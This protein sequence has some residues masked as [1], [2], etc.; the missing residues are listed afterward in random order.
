MKTD[1][2][3]AALAADGHRGIAVP[4]RLAGGLVAGLAISFVVFLAAFGIRADLV[5]ALES[6][7]FDVKVALLALAVVVSSI[8]CRRA[9]EPM[10]QS[11]GAL[12]WLVPAAL[13]VAVAGELASSPASSW[14]ARLVG[15]NAK[16]CLT[17]IPMLALAPLVLALIALR[18]AAPRSPM[19][20]GAA[21]GFA[22][23]AIAA[24]LYGLHCFDDSPLFVATWYPLASVPVVLAGAVAG[25]RLLR[26]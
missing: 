17:A 21:A 16:V 20:A 9:A 23:S 13:A 19:L 1:E 15:T 24:V 5:P 11:H 22:A 25:H 4:R 18:T 6:W 7:R 26:W 2:L 12:A 14:T 10:P 8:V 3:I